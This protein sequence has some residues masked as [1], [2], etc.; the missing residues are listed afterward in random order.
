MKV[1]QVILAIAIIVVLVLFALELT[2]STSYKPED[3]QAVRLTNQRFALLIEELL[4]KEVRN[5]YSIVYKRTVICPNANEKQ[6]LLLKRARIMRLYM[7]NTYLKTKEL[8]PQVGE[9]KSLSEPVNFTNDQLTAFKEAIDR[10]TSDMNSLFPGE[11]AVVMSPLPLKIGKDEYTLSSL[12]NAPLPIWEAAMLMIR[13][14]LLETERFYAFA[15]VEAL[16][17]D[18][19]FRLMPVLQTVPNSRTISKD[20]TLEAEIFLSHDYMPQRL[21]VTTNTGNLSYENDSTKVL[22]K[23]PTKGL[24]LSFDE[25][26]R[27]TQLVKA[28]VRVPDM[29]AYH[30]L[31]VEKSFV[32]RKKK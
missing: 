32:V 17:C 25:K 15:M 12:Q 10:Y 20:G 31:V 21:E 28:T 8:T 16:R 29:T 6:D 24:S 5:L 26:G 11:K 14:S 27:A 30:E 9:E 19:N 22:L 18:K 7:L 13:S 4:N 3:Y 1:L 23:I 2:D